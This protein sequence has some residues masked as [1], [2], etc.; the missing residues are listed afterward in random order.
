MERGAWYTWVLKRAARSNIDFS[1]NFFKTLS[2]DIYLSLRFHGAMRWPPWSTDPKD[3]I[4]KP[5]VPLPD[6]KY[7]PS[8][9]SLA[10]EWASFD[11]DV[12]IPTAIFAGTIIL[13]AHFYRS[14]LRRIPR[15][16]YISG[17]F[18]RKRSVF[19]NVTSVGDGD[20]FRLFHTPGGRLTGWG[21]MPGRKIPKGRALK[22]QTVGTILLQDYIEH[23]GKGEIQGGKE[24]V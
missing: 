22:D 19:G 9:P 7:F 2:L 20:G 13:S 15:A 21:W 14:F 1:A 8:V 6:P 11:L 3:D 10:K 18:F 17:S 4:S 24:S 16:A 5:R 23:S 12:L